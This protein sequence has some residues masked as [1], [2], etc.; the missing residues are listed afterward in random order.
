VIAFFRSRYLLPF[1]IAVIQVS[2]AFHVHG[3][4]V[5][6]LDPFGIGLLLAGPG[7]L[8]VRRWFPRE[9][10]AFVFVTTLTFHW[11]D[12]S[13]A[14]VFLSLIAAFTS[15]FFHGHRLFAWVTLGLTYLSF[16]WLGYWIGIEPRPEIDQA[17]GAAAWML[18]F[19][20]FF[21]VGRGRRERAIEAS[22]VRREE[23][24]RRASEERLRIARELHDVLGHNLSL[25]NVQAGSALHVMEERP[26][27]ARSALQAIKDASNDALGDL[28]SVLDILREGEEVP[29]APM[30]SLTDLDDLIENT[31]KAGLEAS[32]RVVGEARHLPA[33]IERAAFRIAQEAL[34]NVV[35]HA[36]ARSAVITVTY[37]GDALSI[38]VVDDGKG[39]VDITEGN[40]IAGM[41]ERATSLRG[42][43]TAGAKPGG[44][45]RVWARLPLPKEQA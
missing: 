25:I 43:M 32:K 20:A 41:R 45:F 39:A 36:D 6:V 28:R 11:L 40:G 5:P 18:A 33:N 22:R 29:R 2:G 24:K 21:E 34:T 26:E 15:A 42:E 13:D 1:V 19:F 4:A 3:G 12:Y 17:F 30:P 44:G 23:S 14:P 9:T 8:T 37:G 27:Q 16:F 35:R 38:E 7:A 31:R 10:L